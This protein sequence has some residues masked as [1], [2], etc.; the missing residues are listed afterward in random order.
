MVVGIVMLENVDLFFGDV[1][2][3]AW[4]RGG[5]CWEYCMQEHCRDSRC[6]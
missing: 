5:I 4:D 2:M 1:R 3:A 6:L